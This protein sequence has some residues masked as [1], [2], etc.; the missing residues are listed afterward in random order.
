MNLNTVKAAES[1]GTGVMSRKTSM[2]RR[3][4]VVGHDATCFRREMSINVNETSETQVTSI[5]LPDRAF[6]GQR[7]LRGRTCL[8]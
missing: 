4:A 7:G 2:A 1:P 6:T 3:K 5:R 8:S